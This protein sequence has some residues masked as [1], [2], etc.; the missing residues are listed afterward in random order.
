M[1][2]FNIDEKTAMFESE[3]YIKY[4][5]LFQDND[6]ESL[7][8]NSNGLLNI[9]GSYIKPPKVK[10]IFDEINDHIIKKKEL[11]IKYHNIYNNIL[12]SDNPKSLQK[13]YDNIINQLE[14]VDKNINK[15]NEYY[16]LINGKNY[17]IFI[18]NIVKENKTLLLKQSE[19]LNINNSDKSSIIKMVKLYN[20]IFKNVEMLEDAE[21]KINK[22]DFYIISLPEFNVKNKKEK[23][24]TPQKMEK[25]KEE[26]IELELKPKQVSKPN[27]K[28]TPQQILS[29][30]SNVKKLI[31]EK[32][33]FKSK[34]ECI[35]QK[36]KQS[37]YM[38]KPELID[39]IEKNKEIKALL[40]S[41]YQ[42]LSKEK[43]CEYL[44]F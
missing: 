29:I 17:D 27:L 18:G 13:D 28:V 31:A 9:G 43:I 24:Q 15:L 10:N 33:K 39:E 38:S 2:V 6:I 35:S 36:H 42:K 34:D 1:D 8:F 19:L 14:I 41:N 12:Y 44:N 32:F 40:P 21:K 37:Y 30:K 22:I 4:L 20:E 5:N 16:E 23:V 25:E 3:A 26:L 11:S 7:N